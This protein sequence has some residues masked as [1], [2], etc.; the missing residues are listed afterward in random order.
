MEKL[1]LTPQEILDKQ[2]N[3]DFKGYNADDVDA[4]LDKVLDDYY[5]SEDN[6]QELLDFIT[7]LQ[8]ELKATKARVTEL[9]TQLEGQKKVFDLSKTTTYSSVDILKRISRLEEKLY[10]K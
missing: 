10:N 8:E 4:F 9:E 6:V 5:K 2:F 1:N 3:V 7:S